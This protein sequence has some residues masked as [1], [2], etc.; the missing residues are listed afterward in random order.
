MVNK[1]E[2][3]MKKGAAFLLAIMCVLLMTGCGM[4]TSAKDMQTVENKVSQEN[5]VSVN[6]DNITSQG[7]PAEQYC[8][9][10][11]RVTE[12][13]FMSAE[14]IKSADATVIYDE[15]AE[16]YSI[17]L[18]IETNGKVGEEQIEQYKSILSEKYEYA[19]VVLVVDGEVM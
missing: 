3:L 17:K 10:L 14:D 2:M 11:K 12:E 15:E 5:T 16:Q 13:V 6:L 18:S 1:E 19:E 9:Y 7:D 8:A 4:I